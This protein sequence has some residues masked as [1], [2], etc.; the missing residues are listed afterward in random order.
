MAPIVASILPVRSRIQSLEDRKARTGP[1]EKMSKQSAEED[2]YPGIYF[3]N[4]TGPFLV[5]KIFCKIFQ[6]SVTSNL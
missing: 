5:P 3:R 2:Y 4:P 1:D 6:I